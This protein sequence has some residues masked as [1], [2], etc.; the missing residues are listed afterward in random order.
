MNFLLNYPFQL[1][2]AGTFSST[3]RQSMKLEVSR[4]LDSA[5]NDL[6]LIWN[7]I[8]IEENQR[9]DRQNVVLLHLQNLLDEMVREEKEMKKKLLASVEICGQEVVKL[10]AELRVARFEVS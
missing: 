7:E 3:V 2:T 9:D 4:C 1:L 5:L 10:S 6:I 8:G